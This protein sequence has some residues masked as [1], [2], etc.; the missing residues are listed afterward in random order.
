MKMKT[1]RCLFYSMYMSTIKLKK[2]FP[3]SVKVFKQY[4]SLPTFY[5]HFHSLNVT[6]KC[7]VR[8]NTHQISS[9]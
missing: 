7:F 9:L 5:Q 1:A 2:D 8:F 6:F 3:S 4:D